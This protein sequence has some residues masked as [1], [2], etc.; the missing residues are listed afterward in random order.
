MRWFRTSSLLLLTL[1]QA[2]AAQTPQGRISGIVTSG[3]GSRP[4][5]GA[6]IVIEGTRLGT[7]TRSDGRYVITGVPAGTHRVRASMLGYAPRLSDPIVLAEGGTAS[8]DFRLTPQ[9]QALDQVVVTGYG[10]SSRRELTGAIASVSGEDMTLKAAPTSALSNALQGKAAGVQVTTNSGVPGAGASVRVRGTNSI[11]A[12]SEPLY[13]IDGI[14]AAQGT[15]S[16]D[17]TFN[18]L[19]SID[20]S[21]IESIDILKDASATAIYGARGANGVVMV[22]TKHGPRSGSLTTI[23][24]SYGVQTISKRLGTMNG[25]QYMAL[26]NEAYLNAGRAAPYTA[27]QIAAAQSYD[28]PSMMIQSAPQQSHAVSF[29]GGDEKT[30]YLISG[31][32]LNQKGILVNSSFTRYGARVNLDREM[33]KRFRLGTSISMTRSEQGLNRTEN[34]GI[35]AGANGILGA[36]NF[37]PT[38]APRNDVGAWNLKATLGEQL[39][40]PLANALEIQNPRRV[41]RLLGSAFGEYALSDALRFRSTL[42]T[43]FA[44]E[45]TPEYRPSTSPAG[46]QFQGWGSVYSNQGVELTNENTVDYRR[47]VFGSDLGL[48]GGFSVQKSNFEDQYA[49]AQTFPNDAFAFNNLGA[50][51]TRS[52]IGTNAVDWTILSYLGRATYNVRDKYLFTVTGRADGSSRFAVNNKWAFFPSA[53][54]AWRAIDEDFMKSHAAFSDLKFRISYGVTGNQAINEY[55]SLARLSTVFVPVGRNNEV[56]ALAPSGGAANPNLKWETQ[57]QLNA[58]VDAGFVNNRLLVSLDVY[59]SRTRDL[60]LDVP[61]PRSSGFSSQLQNVG[62]VRNRG[63]ELSLTTVNASSDRF[64]WRSTLNVSTNRNMVLDLGG[65]DFIDPGTSRYGFFIGN[66]SSHI[67]QV[68]Q[69]LGSF[70]GFKVNGIFQ[71]GDVCPLTAPRAGVDCVPGEYNVL[72]ATGDGKIDQSD[73]VILGTAEPKVY[74]GLSNSFST[75]PWSVDAFINFSQG[76]KA[77]NIGRTWTE[78]ATGFLNESDRVLNRWTPTNT[79]TDVPRANNGRPR[80][81]YSPM[82]ED[83]SFIR[84]QNVTVGYQLPRLGFVPVETA[85]LYVTGQNLFVLTRYT[86]FDP[87]VNGI[88]GDPRLP[89][90][91]VGAYPRARTWNT[92]LSVTF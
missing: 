92:G 54:F 37:D 88:G 17:P 78:L 24:T 64:S 2:L 32:A 91:D 38:I 59:Q 33:S 3:E 53:A 7:A 15:R 28:Y 26:R 60:L 81:L 14:P 62:S 51:K 30:R 16:S 73:R 83:A 63:V 44:T 43:N 56:V 49:E 71:P 40:N 52:G 31:N 46:A 75:G 29:T 27:A 68:G 48:L 35:G 76:N 69:P 79:N 23:E 90:V 74:G 11:T 84:L 8:L 41:S 18:P 42:G 77:A 36:M 13:V 85:R 34:G 70:Y 65:R 45:R 72:D 1:S 22:T 9:A 20:P 50:G 47:N 21:E 5:E 12:N 82:V 61:L 89:G 87:E 66:M 25:P 80:W 19:N 55:Q 10:T 58:G 6:R 57:N 39:D 86:G 67:V 4:L